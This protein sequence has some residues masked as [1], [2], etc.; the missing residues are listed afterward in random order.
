MAKDNNN[1]N[2]ASFHNA[3]T[4]GSKIVGTITADSDFRVDGYV[5]GDLTCKGKVVVGQKGYIKGTID[6]MNAE[7]YGTIDGKMNVSEILTLRQ[8]AVINGEINVGTLI[9]EPN[10]TF[11][12]TCVMNK[13]VNT[14]VQK[15]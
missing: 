14:T 1:N 13:K 3:L 2:G 8:T 12:G 9:I 6:C 5:E 10:A 15:K 7:I 11:N 4:A